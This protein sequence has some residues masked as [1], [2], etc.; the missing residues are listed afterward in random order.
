M[1]KIIRL[2][3]NDFARIVRRVIQENED[4][5]IEMMFD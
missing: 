2:T 5:D 1:K 3:E 4:D